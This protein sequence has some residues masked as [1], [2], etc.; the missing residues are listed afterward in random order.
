MAPSG[1]V[2]ALQDLTDVDLSLAGVLVDLD[3][4]YWDDVNG[5]W[6]HG[7][8]A[9]GI[10]GDPKFFIPGVLSAV[11]EAH[12]RVLVVRDWIIESIYIYAKTLGTAGNTILDVNK[13]GSTIFTTTANRPTL[14]Y[15]D[16][17]GWAVSGTPDI[18]GFV[19]GDV[20]SF[21]LDSVA[22]GAADLVIVIKLADSTITITPELRMFT[23]AMEG[24]LFTRA[25]KARMYNNFGMNFEITKVFIAVDAAPTGS[26]IKVDI[27]KSPGGS[28]FP[29]G[30]NRPQIAVSTFTGVSTT[31]DGDFIFADGD[32]LTMDVDQI[33]S[34]YPGA[35]LVVNVY[36]R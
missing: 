30:A 32:Y 25:G 17:N 13:N 1:G 10:Q 11:T 22:T 35:D 26:A 21:D 6:S 16:G 7:H 29:S 28:L 36:F 23:W 5:K 9:T 20:I 14:A 8:P 12:P 27:N 2:S 34:S 15:N 3:S 18:A 4:L 31:F 19:E 24:N 33:G